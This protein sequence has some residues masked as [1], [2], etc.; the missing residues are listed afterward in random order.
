MTFVHYT[1]LR[2]ELSLKLRTWLLKGCPSQTSI[3]RIHAV[4][5]NFYTKSINFSK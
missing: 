1:M 5:L 4:Q 3:I 2:A